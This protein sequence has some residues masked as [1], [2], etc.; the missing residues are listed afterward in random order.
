MYGEAAGNC[1]CVMMTIGCAGAVFRSIVREPF[2]AQPINA[3]IGKRDEHAEDCA[4]HQSDGLFAQAAADE[5]RQPDGKT[6]AR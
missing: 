5:G 6:D 4:R 2:T 1:G 3:P